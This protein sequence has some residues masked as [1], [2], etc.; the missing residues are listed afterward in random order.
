MEYANRR[1]QIPAG[2]CYYVYLTLFLILVF[3]LF[4]PSPSKYAPSAHLEGGEP[5]AEYYTKD[6]VITAWNRNDPKSHLV[7]GFEYT[8]GRLTVPVGGRYYVY[9]Q[10]FFNSRKYHNSNRVAVYAGNRILLMIHKDMPPFKENTGFAGGVFFLTAGE[11]IYVKVFAFD[12]RIWM[13]PNHCY[14]G[15]YLI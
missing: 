2:G 9:F 6:Q 8:N 3:Y 4:Y 10:M 15:A 12:V 7:N 13:E 5:W 11:K 14:F 1:L